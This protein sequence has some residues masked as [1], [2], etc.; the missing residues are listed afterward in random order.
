[1]T[2]FRVAAEFRTPLLTAEINRRSRGCWG[3]RGRAG[4][5]C[6]AGRPRSMTHPLVG[7]VN[8]VRRYTFRQYISRA[9]NVKPGGREM[10]APG[11]AQKCPSAL[12][13]CRATAPSE[14]DLM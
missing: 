14:R 7:I 3:W 4:R 9:P 11:E 10:S 5:H 6:R 8:P 12:A 2:F 1:M 13:Q